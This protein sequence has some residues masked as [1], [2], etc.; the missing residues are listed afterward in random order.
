MIK[1][2]QKQIF[3]SF[4]GALVIVFNTINPVFAQTAPIRFE[5]ISTENGL[6]D[7]NVMTILQDQY[8]FMWFGTMNGLNKYDGYEFT[9][10]QN[11]PEDKDT[12][13]G[14]QIFVIYE[15]SKHNLWLGTNNGL[16]RYIR[17]TGKFVHYQ[18]EINNK[19]SLE[20]KEVRAIHEDSSGDLWVGTTDGGINRLNVQSGTFTHYKKRF[21]NAASLSDNCVWSFFEDNYGDLWIGTNNGL[22]RYDRKNDEFI[23]FQN[24]PKD[25]N[26][27]TSAPI[28]SITEDFLG[29]LW[30]GTEGGG[31]EMFNRSEGRFITFLHSSRRTTSIADNTVWAVNLDR[32][33][34]LWVGTESGLNAYNFAKNEFSQIN[35]DRSLTHSD[36]NKRIEVIYEDRTGVLWIAGNNNGVYKFSQASEKFTLYQSQGNT[37]YSLSNSAVLTLLEDRKGQ[38]WVGTYSGGV[39]ILNRQTGKVT[40]L[41]ND[42]EDESSLSSN[43]V[44]SIIE[45]QYGNIWIG[46]NFGGLDKYNS[47][48]NSFTHYTHNSNDS[49]SLSEDRVTVLYQ[50]RS[51]QIWAGT[52]SE[53]LNRLDRRSGSFYNFQYQPDNPNSLIDDHIWT[54]YEDH[55]GFL[56]IG[57]WGGISRLDT[58]NNTFTN[59]SH[60]P[61][62]PTSLSNNNVLS[63][64]ESSD[65]NMWIGTNDGGLNVLDRLTLTF[66]HYTEEDGLPDNT[67]YG[68]LAD[69]DGFLWLSTKSG[70]SKFDPRTETFRNYDERDGLQANEFNVGAHFQSD[71]GEMFFGGIKGFNSFFPRQVRDNPHIPPVIITEFSKSGETV[72]IDII[73]DREYSITYQDYILS[74]EFA[75]L[76]FTAPEKNLYAYKLE[77]YDTDWIYSSPIKVTSHANMM[78]GVEQGWKYTPARRYAIYP[79]LEPGEYVFRVKGSNNDG[80]W[81]EEGISIKLTVTP[82]IWQENWFKISAILVSILAVVGTYT[83]RLKSIE[84]RTRMLQ[85][86]VEE[87][88][89]EIEQRRQVAECLRE[90]LAIINSNKPI[91]EILD[92]IVLQAS[93]LLEASAC[94]LYKFD[95][96]QACIKMVAEFQLPRAQTTKKVFS[97]NIGSITQTI[98]EREPYAIT[99]IQNSDFSHLYDWEDILTIKWFN[100]LT[101]YSAFL[102]VPVVVGEELYGF[103]A[104]YYQTQQ[105]FPHDQVELALSFADQTA[106]AI[107]NAEL[108]SQAEQSAI[109]AERNRLARDLHDAVTQTLFSA[110]II[111]EVL[112]KIWDRNQDEGLKRL[113]EL[114][115][116]TRGALAEMRTL[117]L[118]LRPASLIETDFN[119]LLKQLADAFVGRARI[120][121]NLDIQE[122]IILPEETQI[123][124]YRIAQESL[125]NIAK[126]SNATQVW[127]NIQ[128]NHRELEMQIIDN[129]IGFNPKHVSPKSLGLGFM[130]ERADNIGA[131]IEVQSEIDKGTHITVKLSK[132]NIEEEEKDE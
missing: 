94:A 9:I 11:D 74:F 12:I 63:F 54:I 102:A 13:A 37:G 84:N 125:N 69:Q 7:N 52:Y 106:L 109:A 25:A 80:L 50:D 48:T 46:T 96:P 14:N 92:H 77:G 95:L 104:F 59:Y 123:A 99:D 98:K 108:R 35:Y 16:D 101:K 6:S 8:G 3:L 44:R 29:N 114:R 36:D 42:P 19:D 115:Q 71:T 65:G 97:L 93:G 110:S 20:G 53:G 58:L 67:I 103:L 121:V 131:K 75:A 22:N 62:D 87:R 64:Y 127:I 17:E 128:S 126:H 105:Q 30:L 90:T 41:Q 21:S 124:V 33:G 4:I 10:F 107:E 91:T 113:E 116:L 23:V 119:D 88:T 32:N 60:D 100:L 24:D 28:R 38:I 5:N 76:D 2:L 57:T 68:I 117:L 47:R 18:H 70:L 34:T 39:N 85:T 129:G 89:H 78:E 122:T 112:P 55:M 61:N 79:N 40:Y 118:E 15:D 83:L 27:I 51:S 120:P 132:G 49:K 43:D 26:S 1:N 130:K 73:E 31:L 111:A 81:N 66:K 72:Q 45:D 56:W 86:E 82:P